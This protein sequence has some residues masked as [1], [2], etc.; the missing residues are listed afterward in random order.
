MAMMLADVQQATRQLPDSP[1]LRRRKSS[2]PNPAIASRKPLRD[3][4]GAR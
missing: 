2:P 3:A 4:R 1:A